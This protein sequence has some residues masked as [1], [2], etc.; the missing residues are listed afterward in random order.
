MVVKPVFKNN[1]AVDT[2]NQ[3]D[4]YILCTMEEPWKI[5]E[6]EINIKPTYLEYNFNMSIENLERLYESFEPFITENY[7]IVGMGGGTSCDTAKFLAWKFKEEFRF[8]LDLYLIP[9]I[10]SVDAFLCSSI[11]VRMENKVKYIGESKPKK[12]IIDYSLIRKAPK[13]LNRAGV[14]DTISIASALGDWKLERDEMNGKFDHDMFSRARKIAIELIKARTEIRDVTEKGIRVLVD[15]FYKEV[16]LCEEWGNARPEE[17]SEHFLAYCLEA[18]TGEHYIHGNLIGMSILISL[19]LQENYTEFALD[20]IKQFFI[21]IQL[22][23]TPTQQ[24]ITEDQLKQAFKEIQQYVKQENLMYSIYNSPRLKL[25]DEKI[26]Q[27]LNF[28]KGLKSE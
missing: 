8:N 2:L 4:R 17:G 23:F 27:I 18:I 20:E 3:L 24:K 28:V 10:V 16:E 1:L 15:G 19:F 6:N 14:S 9:S 11:A 26:A 13:F 5:I 12:I 22:A 7:A 25:N 21:D